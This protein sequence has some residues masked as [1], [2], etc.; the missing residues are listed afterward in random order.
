[1]FVAGI[2]ATVASDAG[3]MGRVPDRLRYGEYIASTNGHHSTFA[4]GRNGV[5]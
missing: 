3:G 5:F 2:Y 4:F 1:V